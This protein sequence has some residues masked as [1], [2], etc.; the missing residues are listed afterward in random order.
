MENKCQSH[1]KSKIVF[2]VNPRKR[3]Y[4]TFG[5][6]KPYAPEYDKQG[7]ILGLDKCY[8]LHTIY[9]R[10]LQCRHEKSLKPS[11]D[12]FSSSFL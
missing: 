3:K 5:A 8:G 11:A 7:P 9:L 2:I 12:V 1:E 4:A 6:K 10:S